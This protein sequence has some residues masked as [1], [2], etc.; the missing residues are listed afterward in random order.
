MLCER[1]F[2]KLTLA[3]WKLCWL[4]NVLKVA[5]PNLPLHHERC[6]DCWMYWMSLYQTYPCTMKDVLIVECIECRFTKR[7]L[8][9]WKMCWL[10]NVLNVALPNV[11][12]HHESCVD[13][14]M[15]WMS[16]DQTYPCTM[17]DVLIVE[18]IECRLTKHTLAP[19][20]NQ[21]YFLPNIVKYHNHSKSSFVL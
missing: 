14:W 16:L 8:A 17:K 10:L 7:T 1:R 20:K 11:P 4:L 13:C 21:I 18:C 12:L 3:P 15:Y 9:P 19:C 2:T 5:L 6:V